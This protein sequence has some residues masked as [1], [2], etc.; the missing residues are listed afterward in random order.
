MSETLSSGLRDHLVERLRLYEHSSE[1][2]DGEPIDADPVTTALLDAA[3]V[4]DRKMRDAE[5]E[6]VR[7]GHALNRARTDAAFHQTARDAI[8]AAYRPPFPGGADV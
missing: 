2:Q 5:V 6:V 8:L 1:R 7:A 3:L 4:H